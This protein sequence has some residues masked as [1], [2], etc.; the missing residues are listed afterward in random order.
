MQ[1]RANAIDDWLDRVRGEY[2]EMPG[3]RLTLA[4]AARLWSLDHGTC[5]RVLYAL[6]EARFLIVTSDGHYARAASVCEEETVLPRGL[7]TTL[8]VERRARPRTTRRT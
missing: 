1:T 2:L 7:S 5:A 6:V 3:L 8:T 4:Q